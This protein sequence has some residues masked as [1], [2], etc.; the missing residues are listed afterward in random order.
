[1]N[2]GMMTMYAYDNINGT[3]K[4]KPLLNN[5]LSQVKISLSQAAAIAEKDLGT[6]SR[7]IEAYLCEVNGYLVYMTWV[8]SSNADA[9][10]VVIDSGNGKILLKN[11]NLSPPQNPM[12]NHTTMIMP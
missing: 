7:A 4:L 10:D 9:I 12:D 1:M 6:R 11:S 2:P 8:I 3:I 5:T